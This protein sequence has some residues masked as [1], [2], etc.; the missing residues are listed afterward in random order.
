MLS[1]T[2]AENSQSQDDVNDLQERNEQLQEQ[3][4][5]LTRQL[6]AQRESYNTLKFHAEQVVHNQNEAPSELAGAINKLSCVVGIQTQAG[7]FDVSD[8]EVAHADEL[9]VAQGM[10]PLSSLLKESPIEK[11][12]SH[13]GVDSMVYFERWLEMR[14]KETMK[15]KAMLYARTEGKPETD[16]MYEWYLAHAASYQEVMINFRNARQQNGPKAH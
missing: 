8:E 16:E 12:M 2:S 9:L 5:L 4:E 10:I 7:S 3:I 13:V 14:F 15:C 11:F 6:Q 1:N